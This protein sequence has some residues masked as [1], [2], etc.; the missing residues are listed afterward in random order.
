MRDE[1]VRML[2]TK[3]RSSKRLITALYKL[4]GDQVFQIPPTRIADMIMDPTVDDNIVDR[5]VKKWSYHELMRIHYG[6]DS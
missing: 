1:I 3:R 6:Q 5:Y 4:I 2:L